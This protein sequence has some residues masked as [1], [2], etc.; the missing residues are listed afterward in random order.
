MPWGR[1]VALAKRLATAKAFVV[2]GVAADVTE[3]RKFCRT[4]GH[5]TSMRPPRHLFQLAVPQ[6]QPGCASAARGVSLRAPM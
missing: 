1:L 2:G 5:I 6:S 4:E 3:I